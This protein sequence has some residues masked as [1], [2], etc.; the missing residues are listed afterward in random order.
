MKEI[1]FHGRG[2]QGA[3]TAAEMIAIAA[4]EDGRY[5]QAFP[6]FGV[7]R[8]G[9]PV[10]AFAR[11]ADDPIR[12]RSQIYEPDYVV[13]Q[14]VTLLDVVD[15]ASGLKGTGKIIINT[16]RQPSALNLNTKAEVVAID[17]TKIAMET[18]GRPIVNTTMLGAFCGSTGEIK[19]ESLNKALM[20]KFSGEL[21][22]KNLLAIKTA[23]ERVSK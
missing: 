13:V 11:I 2:G 4:Y 23:F 14:D 19:L 16:D 18:L 7:E 22:N 5:S 15:V 21:A 12:I 10:M 8:R 17:A 6:A 9:A 1:R 20:T 3:V